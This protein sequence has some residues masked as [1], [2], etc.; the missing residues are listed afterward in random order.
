MVP[1]ATQMVVGEPSLRS[2][3]HQLLTIL[4]P[5]L[6]TPIHDALPLHTILIPIQGQNRELRRRYDNSDSSILEPLCLLVL[7]V[8][9][10]TLVDRCIRAYNI[11][12]SLPTYAPIP[13]ELE[14]AMLEDQKKFLEEALNRVN[15][16]L[17]ELK[18]EE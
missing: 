5:V 13:R 7:A 9:S 2:S 14:I 1:V 11:V 17:K 15:S 6:A 12:Y 16:R 4:L 8:Q 3:I 10:V 18:K